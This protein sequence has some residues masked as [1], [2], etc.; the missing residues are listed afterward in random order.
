MFKKYK[1]KLI[2]LFKVIL[3]TSIRSICNLNKVLKKT[4]VGLNVFL[5][6]LKNIMTTI[7]AVFSKDFK[8]I[9]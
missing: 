3:L 9:M 1:M 5:Y 8:K 6:T 7:S 4:G 2:R